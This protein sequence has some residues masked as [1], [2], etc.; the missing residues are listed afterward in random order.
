MTLVT[1]DGVVLSTSAAAQRQHRRAVMI[2][3]QAGYAAGA[4]DLSWED[5]W[6]T[7]LRGPHGEW[8]R[9]GPGSGHELDYTPLLD[10]DFPYDKIS[11][12]GGQDEALTAIARLQGFDG[13]PD[14]VSDA[15]LDERVAAG[16]REMW[17]GFNA[18]DGGG[19]A[20]TRGFA[21]EFLH[22]PYF[23]GAGTFGNGNYT[24]SEDTAQ[25]VAEVEKDWGDA[26]RGP[27]GQFTESWV[28]QAYARDL[29]RAKG[30]AREYA[31]GYA[32]SHGTLVRMTLDKNARTVVLKDLLDQ[33]MQQFLTLT[34]RRNT[35]V[36]AGDT[37]AAE[38]TARA[39]KLINDPGRLAAILGYDAVDIPGSPHEVNILNRTAVHASSLLQQPGNAPFFPPAQLHPGAT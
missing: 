17:R 37:A 27:D 7:E 32:S 25:L 3:E 23:A 14:I 31:A 9:G 30:K 20:Q 38:R 6:R 35:E 19:E 16:E 22:G 12:G 39:L 8:I 18:T 2:S 11:T 13:P 5:A 29:A 26:P 15:D 1:S 28:R 21:T 10:R 34:Q 36:E 33:Q 24:A 4:L